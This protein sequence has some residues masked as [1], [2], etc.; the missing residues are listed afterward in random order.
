MDDA[1][2]INAP[3]LES[4]AGASPEPETDA[5][6]QPKPEFDV[7]AGAVEPRKGR[8]CLGRAVSLA[9]L[10]IVA[11]LL[12]GFIGLLKLSEEFAAPEDVA[13]EI[14]VT[15]P[16]GATAAQIG[17][18]LEEAGV[19][20]S[21]RA[22]VLAYR[23]KS[24]LSSVGV[25][26]KAGEMALDPSRN[27]WQTMKLIAK[28]NYK[29]YPF[30]VPEGW[31]IKDIAKNLESQGR[32]SAEEFL[33]LCRDKTFIGSLGLEVDSLEGYL[34]PNTYNFPKNTSLEVMIKTMVNEFLKV[35]KRYAAQAQARG[36][37]RHQAITLASIVEKETGAPEER[38]LIAGVFSNRL[39]RDMKLETDPTV[40]YGL[41]NFSGSITKTDLA[42][43]HPYNTYVHQGLPPGPIANPGE[44]AIA[45][46]ANPAR[47][48]YLFFV[49]KNDGTHH[50]SNTLAEHNRMVNQYQRQGRRA[51]R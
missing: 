8:G 44:L 14:V 21:G 24:R 11:A 39:A 13:R 16:P 35:W 33:R 46:V 43:P 30:T 36:L 23:I 27:V 19:I 18:L 34:F 41:D 9:G 32:G 17:D 4:E 51:N 48:D 29:L 50:F 37:S 47:V 6:D 22:F 3:Q 10:A 20:R 12:A 38:P 5:H 49:S 31:T 7:Y 1:R 25:P 45:A 40:I 15:I 28:G 26:L 2:K 42:N